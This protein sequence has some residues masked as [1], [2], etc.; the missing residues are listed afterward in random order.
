MTSGVR[1]SAPAAALIR[2]VGDAIAPRG[3]GKGRVCVV[4][5]HRVLRHADP[6]LESEPDVDTF[7]WQ[8]RLLKECF[9]VIP[10]H[11]AVMAVASERI[12]PR[13]VCITFDDGY[14][15]VHDLALP[16]L[17]EFGLP[18]TVFVTSGYVGE[19]HMWNDRIIEAVESIPNGELN[20]EAFGLGVYA[21]HNLDER[22]AA[23]AR[24]TESSKYLPPA[25]RDQLIDRLEKM[26]GDKL[27]H[28][29]MLDRQMVVNLA[30]E[31]VE[32][33]AHT[34][35]HP[36]LTSLDDAEARREIVV[37]KQQLEEMT[38]KPV[39]LFAYPNGKVGMDFDERH[40]RMVKEAGFDAAFT[41]AVGSIT[42]AQ[43]KF[44]LP[45]SRPWDT[46]PFRFG[47]RLLRW[48]SR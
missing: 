19:N 21:L 38:G 27:A 47:L 16:V 31:G 9:N 8:M 17:K 26:V 2:T 20:L 41:T 39:R 23:V 34:I 30:R 28:G 46:T 6:L 36:I 11:E 25:A 44:Q 3:K 10:L 14:R 29:L 24:L 48:L 15:S 45:R 40:A 33:G 12:A 22:K 18:A 13:T 32:I 4:N 1:L 5:Y 37:G 43:D 7:R 35:T 42:S